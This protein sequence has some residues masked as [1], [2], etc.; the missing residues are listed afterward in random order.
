M[1]RLLGVKQQRAAFFYDTLFKSRGETTAANI[2]DADRAR[3]TQT[4]FSGSRSSTAD[5]SNFTTSGFLPS[6]ETFL[7]YSVR[8]ELQIWGAAVP[9]ATSATVP[10]PWNTTPG[11]FIGALN[12]LVFSFNVGNKEELGGPWIMT[13]A[14]GGPW[15]FLSDSVDPL[16][17][18]GVPASRS[19]YPLG[20]P[21]AI[22]ILQNVKVVETIFVITG[23]T[24]NVEVN[25]VDAL[26]RYQGMRLGRC[27]LDGY[28]TRDVQ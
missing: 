6:G 5:R 22:A 28:H 26:N 7:C 13:P 15:G 10:A 2:P 27:H 23:T 12:S 18:N 3:T 4:L 25:V 1:S 19:V 24:N 11:V 9:V 21:V 17:D 20:L 8:H 14:G 16:I